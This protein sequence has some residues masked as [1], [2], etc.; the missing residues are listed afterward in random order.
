M[1]SLAAYNL[2][3]VELVG[4]TKMVHFIG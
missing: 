4:E 1:K 2:T 3:K